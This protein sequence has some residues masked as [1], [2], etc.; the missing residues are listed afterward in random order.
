M[1][2]YLIRRNDGFLHAFE[3][4]NAFISMGTIRRIL[5]CVDGVSSIRR[6]F[7]SEDRLTFSVHGVPWV[8]HEPWGDSGRYWIG[9]R[10]AKDHSFDVNPTHAAFARYQSPFRRRWMW[11]RNVSVNSNAMD[12]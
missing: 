2:T 12:A 5:D 7:F 9:P 10:D 6:R 11:I 8:V 3:I 4:G 1:K